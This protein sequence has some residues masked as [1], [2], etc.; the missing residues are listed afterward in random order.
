[1]SSLRLEAKTYMSSHVLLASTLDL[2]TNSRLED[3]PRTG[4]RSMQ[5]RSTV[6]AI[7]NVAKKD[8][9]QL[10]KTCYRTQSFCSLVE[11]VSVPNRSYS[12]LVGREAM[13]GRKPAMLRC[14][15]SGW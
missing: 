9:A 15:T 5:T 3:L 1:M 4:G 13:F 6:N 7:V 12:E 11:L 2:S 8:E 14:R 10:T